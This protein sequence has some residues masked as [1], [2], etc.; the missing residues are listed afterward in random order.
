ISCLMSFPPVYII[1]DL[2]YQFIETLNTNI[3]I[4]GNQVWKILNFMSNN[5]YFK[6]KYIYNRN[7]SSTEIYIKASQ[8]FKSIEQINHFYYNNNNNNNNN[9]INYKNYKYIKQIT[10]CPLSIHL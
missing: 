3:K 2:N 7:L 1:E 4:I 6:H 8:Y 9:N 10:I 5:I